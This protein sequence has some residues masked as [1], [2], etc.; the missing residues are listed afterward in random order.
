MRRLLLLSVLLTFAV[1]IPFAGKAAAQETLEKLAVGTAFADFK[2]ADLDGTERS[3]KSLA[4]KNG[5]LLV[6]LSAQCPV[7]KAY[8][9]RIVAIS[10]AYAKNGISFVGINS[11]ATESLEWIKSNATEVGYK[12]PVLIDKGNVIADKLGADTTPE[13]F[14]FDANNVLLYRGAIDNDRSGKSITDNYLKSA[15]DLTLAGK[16]IDRTTANA[17]GCSIKRKS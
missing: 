3:L 15:F 9:E 2:L 11:N 16:K 13:V 4:G 7:V 1:A 12:F 5:T 8:N 14:Y 17:F 10:D 6:F